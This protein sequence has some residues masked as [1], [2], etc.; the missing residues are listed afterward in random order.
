MEEAMNPYCDQ[1][2]LMLKRAGF[3]LESV[4]MK[5]E[6]CYYRL[7]DRNELLRIAAHKYGGPR[8][9]KNTDVVSKLTISK[10]MA[11]NDEKLERMVATAMGYYFLRSTPDWGRKP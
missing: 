5:S 8:Q 2:A 6:A 4:S 3:V 9:T 7:P 1:A 11:P 10:E